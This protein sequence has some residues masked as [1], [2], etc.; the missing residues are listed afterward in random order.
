MFRDTGIAYSVLKLPRSGSLARPA[1]HRR[2][3][4]AARELLV[5]MLAAQ[6]GTR[7]RDWAVSPPGGLRPFL[8]RKPARATTP[9]LSL[10]HD[11]DTVACCASW[12]GPV[13]IDVQRQRP[14]PRLEPIAAYLG[15]PEDLPSRRDQGTLTRAWAAWEACSKA[16]GRSVLGPLPEFR[17]CL[18][19]LEGRPSTALCIDER[20]D[21]GWLVVACLRSGHGDPRTTRWIPESS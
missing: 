1:Q 10:S 11:G 18:S 6:T 8:L 20:L 14:L 2:A 3:S 19:A 12:S 13:G 15:W 17:D 7:E 9:C 21:D 16:A 5:A 4:G